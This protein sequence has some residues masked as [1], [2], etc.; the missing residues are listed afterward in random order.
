VAQVIAMALVLS[1]LAT[2]YPSWRAARTD[3]IEALRSE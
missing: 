2:L 3:P 1:L